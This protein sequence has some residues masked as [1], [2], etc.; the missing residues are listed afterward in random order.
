VFLEL[1]YHTIY[2]IFIQALKGLL[3]H[4]ELKS[5]LLDIGRKKKERKTQQQEVVNRSRSGALKKES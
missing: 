1:L 4:V 5:S 3:A 2:H